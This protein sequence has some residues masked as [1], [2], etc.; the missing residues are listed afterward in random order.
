VRRK[1]R[2][3]ACLGFLAVSACSGPWGP[4]E[5]PR[6]TPYHNEPLES[7]GVPGIVDVAARGWSFTGRPDRYTDQEWTG[8]GVVLP[9]G[10]RVALNFSTVRRAVEATVAEPGLVPVPVTQLVYRNVEWDLAIVAIDPGDV[11]LLVAPYMPLEAVQDEFDAITFGIGAERRPGRVAGRRV[12]M[13]DGAALSVLRF[14]PEEGSAGGTLLIA[15][16]NVV[17]ILPAKPQ[18]YPGA[19]HALA[20]DY[21]AALQSTEHEVGAPLDAYF[22]RGQ[23]AEH[24]AWAEAKRVPLPPGGVTLLGPWR[25]AGDRDYAAKVSG[26]EVLVA[27]GRVTGATGDRIEDIEL[28]ALGDAGAAGSEVFFTA[29]AT[30]ELVVGVRNLGTSPRN[31]S[32]QVGTVDW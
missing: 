29:P 20:M 24:M 30:E 12:V 21:V 19:V 7:L 13:E 10:R 9:G 28:L 22:A 5:T 25:V 23:E 16:G 1:L 31:V 8:T 3:E 4:P 26:E 15:D 27:V 6:E 11:S 32:V 2:Y 17:G 14:E 18:D